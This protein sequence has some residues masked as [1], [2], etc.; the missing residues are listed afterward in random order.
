MKNELIHWVSGENP[1]QIKGKMN[2]TIGESA[3]GYTLQSSVDCI[4]LDGKA[5]DGNDATWADYSSE[6]DANCQHDVKNVSDNMW[7][8]LKDNTGIVY[9]RM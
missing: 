8:R 6:I 7:F 2:F 3:S 9:I 4:N 1:F 5:P